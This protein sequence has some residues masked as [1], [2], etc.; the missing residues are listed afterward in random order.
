MNFDYS[1][2]RDKIEASESF[3]SCLSF[4]Q[5]LIETFEAYQRKFCLLQSLEK[6][7]YS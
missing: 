4:S 3:F 5:A 6:E 2:R 1:K 7:R